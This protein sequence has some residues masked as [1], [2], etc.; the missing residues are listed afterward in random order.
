M[1]SLRKRLT[2]RF[3]RTDAG[4]EP[5]RDWLLSL[6]KGDPDRTDQKIVGKD[7]ARVEFGWPIGMPICRAIGALYEVRSTIRSGRV[8]ARVYFGI[9]GADMI[10]LHGS[11]DK[12]D[13][14]HAIQVALDRWKNYRTRKA[15]MARNTVRSPGIDR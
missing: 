2:A 1:Q 12:A 3:Y 6:S 8:E 5:V 7:I 4:N 10:L 15:D 14:A 11:D 9:D 13:Q